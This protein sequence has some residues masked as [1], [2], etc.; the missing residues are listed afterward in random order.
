MCRR[1]GV[2]FKPVCNGVNAA[3]FQINALFLLQGGSY[4][5]NVFN[6]APLYST[7]C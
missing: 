7:F 4:S 3:L 2:C 6:D 1:Y 5:N